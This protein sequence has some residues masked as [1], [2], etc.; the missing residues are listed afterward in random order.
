MGPS[1]SDTL[2]FSEWLLDFLTARVTLAYS[3]LIIALSA[4]LGLLES[5]YPG[6]LKVKGDFRIIWSYLLPRPMN[7]FLEIHAFIH[8][9]PLTTFCPTLLLDTC[10][11]SYL[12]SFIFDL[13]K[14]FVL[15]STEQ[16][17][18]LYLPGA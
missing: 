2:W 1:S 5:Q 15:N 10:L 3:S 14:Y 7:T 17:F 12:L 13:N 16:S 8:C 4:T 9:I 18:A 11:I 6:T